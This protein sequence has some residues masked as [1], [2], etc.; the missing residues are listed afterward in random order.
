MRAVF[1][2]R[3]RE[4]SAAVQRWIV[5]KAKRLT[6]KNRDGGTLCQVDMVSDD[7]VLIQLTKGRRL[8]GT[9]ANTKDK[10]ADEQ[11]LPR[12]GE[13]GGDRGSDEDQS[14]DEDGSTAAEKVVQRVRKP[15]TTVGR[16]F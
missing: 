5:D 10:T 15:A 8:T 9:H 16:S 11:C 13:A 1:S 6:S 14:S 2:C 12:M 3:Q 7:P 4:V